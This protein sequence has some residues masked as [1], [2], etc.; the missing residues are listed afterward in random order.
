MIKDKF[1]IVKKMYSLCKCRLSTCDTVTARHSLSVT[2]N[3]QNRTVNYIQ[4]PTIL[5]IIMACFAIY[6]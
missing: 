5:N 4:S 3:N 1:I 6:D 2:T